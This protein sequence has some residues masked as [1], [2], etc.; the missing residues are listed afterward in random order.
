MSV[1]VHFV[2]SGLE[3]CGLELVQ[4]LWM[5]PQRVFEFMPQTGLRLSSCRESVF[6][7]SGGKVHEK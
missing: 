3:S 4:A 7:Y 2:L 5:L 6:W 1:L